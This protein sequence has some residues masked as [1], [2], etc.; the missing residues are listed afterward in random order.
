LTEAIVFLF[1]CAA[2]FAFADWRQ[3]FAL[4]VVAGILQDP[5]RKIAP[6]QPVYFVVLVGVVFMAAWI[7]AYASRLKLN[8]NAVVGWR[9]QMGLPYSIFLAL[10]IA[11]AVHSYFNFG[12]VLVT[13]IGLLVWLAPVPAV[14]LAYQFALRRGLSGL[15]QWMTFYCISATVSLTGVY[16]QYA[17]IEWAPLGEVGKGLIIYDMGT[18]L[19]AYSGFFRSSEIAAWHTATISCFVFILLIGK[20]LTFGRLV[21]AIVMICLLLGLGVLTGRRKMLVEV[22]VFLSMYA[23]LWA[24]FQRG[25]TRVAVTAAAIGLTFY[26]GAVGLMDPDVS[27]AAGRP[28]TYVL[29]QGEL[30]K[31]YAARGQTVFEDIPNRFSAMGIA[32]I[33]SAILD[34]GWLGGGLGTGSQGVDSVASLAK[35]NRG[36]SEGGFGKIVVELGVPGLL[37]MTWLFVALIRYA[38]QVLAI[39]SQTSMPHARLAF[40]FIAFLAAKVASFSIATQAYS[41]LFILLIMGFA[42]GFF[43]AMPVLARQ[44]ASNTTERAPAGRSNFISAGRTA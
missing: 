14:V 24:V 39:T 9:K 22:A 33:T 38:R 19:K 40:G 11:Q 10:V 35:R 37:V 2:F 32:P 4:C 6:G 1:L 27:D 28:S 12:S 26:V 23:V 20:R 31:G 13:G 17:G 41:D 29:K 18:I 8:P 15:R 43:L 30:Y 36:A 42:F 16:L 7:G 21:L 25:A 44:S 34:F 3:G 5:L